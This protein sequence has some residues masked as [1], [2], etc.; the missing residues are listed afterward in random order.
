MISISTYHRIE[1]MLE[2]RTS[3]DGTLEDFTRWGDCLRAVPENVRQ[4]AGDRT[5]AVWFADELPAFELEDWSTHREHARSWVLE[6]GE[7]YIIFA[8]SRCTVSTD[9]RTVYRESIWCLAPEGVRMIE[10][11]MV[12]QTSGAAIYVEFT[13]DFPQADFLTPEFVA[14]VQ[15]ATRKVW[16]HWGNPLPDDTIVSGNLPQFESAFRAGAQTQAVLA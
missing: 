16:D 8:S 7:N 14:E 10:T 3:I 1:R 9:E 15:S 4:I 11:N 12:A 6:R 5:I 13:G 2:F